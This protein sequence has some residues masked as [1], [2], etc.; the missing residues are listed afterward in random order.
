MVFEPSTIPAVRVPELHRSALVGQR[1][2]YNERVRRGGPHN[3]VEEERSIALQQD[4]ELYWISADMSELC[5][6]ASRDL[7]E[8]H[9]GR[10]LWP[11][12]VGFM[13]F[14][15]PLQLRSAVWKNANDVSQEPIRALAWHESEGGITVL[16]FTDTDAVVEATMQ[17]VG[18]D[19]TEERRGRLRQEL[20]SR[21][22][23]ITAAGGDWYDWTSPVRREDISGGITA[24]VVLSTIWLLMG[25]R[26]VAT[27]ATGVPEP[28]NRAARRRLR[29][30]RPV[31]D[32]VRLVEIRAGSGNA[33]AY[34]GGKTREYRHRWMVKGHWRNQWFPSVGLHRPVW[35]A[36]YL[37]GRS[38]A[39]LLTGPKVN[40]WKGR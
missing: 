32:R 21:V 2:D 28:K 26:G 11:A 30:D 18:S 39:P 24:G 27:V 29:Y 12:D 38:D 10:D 20:H 35:I 13:V 3:A 40:V 16:L 19:I 7:P 5:Y 22:G 36:P 31:L 23:P 1:W 34:S 14:A 15:T 9:L 6:D 25:Q 8:V 4:A 33:D 37:K 17:R